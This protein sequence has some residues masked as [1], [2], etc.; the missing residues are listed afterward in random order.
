LDSRFTRRGPSIFFQS[1]IAI[2]KSKI[3]KGGDVDVAR[4]DS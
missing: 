1:Q 3:M 2:R 4:A